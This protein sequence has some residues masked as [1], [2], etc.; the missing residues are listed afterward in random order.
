MGIDRDALVEIHQGP[1]EITA[2]IEQCAAVEARRQ[3]VGVFLDRN[4]EVLHGL[5][6]STEGAVGLRPVD[7]NHGILRVELGRLFEVAQCGADL[8]HLQAQAAAHRVQ[9]GRIREFVDALGQGL[10]GQFQASLALVLQGHLDQALGIE[11]RVRV[12]L[13]MRPDRLGGCGRLCIGHAEVGNGG[14]V[15]PGSAATGS[16]IRGRRRFAQYSYWNQDERKEKKTEKS[17]HGCTSEMKKASP[18]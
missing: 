10:Q 9:L 6:V 3:Q 15:I 7:P 14:G 13:A 5:V 18:A 11:R 1:F 17:C 4:I 8:L 16:A 2:G 12:V